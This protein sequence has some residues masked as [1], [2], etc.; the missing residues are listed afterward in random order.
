MIRKPP[1]GMVTAMLKLALAVSFVIFLVLA[2]IAGPGLP[3]IT[4]LLV[5]ILNAVLL[6]L[7]ELE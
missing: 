6:C 4:D 2:T 7:L 5:A 3:R 1:P